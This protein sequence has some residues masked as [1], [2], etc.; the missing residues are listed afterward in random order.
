MANNG[1][2]DTLALDDE[3]RLP[4]LEP[5]YEDDDEDEVS[6]V[7]LGALILAGLALLG[8]V[9]GAVYMIRNHFAEQEEPQVLSAPKGA[10]KVPAKS[11]DAKKFAGEGDETFAASEGKERGGVIDPSK[12]PE[13]PMTTTAASPDA[14]AGAK[15]AAH[16]ASGQKLVAPVAKPGQQQAAPKASAATAPAVK[17]SGPMIQLG[18]YNSDAL[19][20]SS[21]ARLSKRF[22][23]LGALT[24]HIEP[25]TVNGTQFY[26]LR[27]ATP[28]ASLLCG[29]LK[30]AGE[31]CLV[32]N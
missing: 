21:W 9:V 32:V 29:K 31:S 8:L 14:A 6:L 20:R 30:V 4:W 18:A 11:A 28:Q 16:A 24:Y 22:D 15:P 25:V 12:L 10:Y 19:A 5:A 17:N 2:N 7:R 23:Y 26:R 3:D 27:A 1:M 13:A